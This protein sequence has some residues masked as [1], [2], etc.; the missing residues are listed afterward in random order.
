VRSAR[1]LKY[2]PFGQFNDERNEEPFVCE[3]EKTEAGAGYLAGPT[4]VELPL[5]VDGAP[6][7]IV[8]P[9]VAAQPYRLV[10]IGEES[11]LCEVLLPIAEEIGAELLLPTGEASDV[12]T[13]NMAARAAEDAARPKLSISPTLIL[14]VGRCQSASVPSY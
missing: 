5:V 12:M 10:M 14:P 3:P 8:S 7:L 1:W 11:S 4:G 9:A 2:V 13:Y 6:N